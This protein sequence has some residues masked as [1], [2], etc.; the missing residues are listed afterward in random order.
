VESNWW[1]IGAGAILIALGFLGL[2]VYGPTEEDRGH[3]RRDYAKSASAG[4]VPC[5]LAEMEVRYVKGSTGG[6]LTWVVECRGRCW[7]CGQKHS[8]SFLGADSYTRTCIGLGEFL[9]GGGC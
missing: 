8:P 4:Q 5:F 1:W 6:D 9:P 7:S 3:V 2:Q